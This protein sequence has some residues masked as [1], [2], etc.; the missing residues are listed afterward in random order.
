MFYAAGG[1]SSVEIKRTGNSGIITA[2]LH[3]FIALLV[4]FGVRAYLWLVFPHVI[5]LHEA[6]AIAYIGIARNIIENFSISNA[7][8]FP[9]FYPALI[10]L[11]SLVAGNY[12]SGARWASILAGAG[13]VVPL[14]LACRQLMSSR[15]AF[16]AV[17]LA[18]GFD[19][20]VDYS[21]QPITQASYGALIA[22]GVWLGLRCIG[23]SAPAL[24]AAFGL[25]SAA[26]YLT[27]PE[28]ILF[29]AFNFP[30][31]V[32]AICKDTGELKGR[33]KRILVL[34]AGF[35]IPF[36]WYVSFLKQS[37]GHWSLS[38][39]SGVT[40]IGVDASLKL[41]PGGLTYGEAVAGTAGISNLFPGIAA[42]IKT[43]LTQ[44]GKF[45]LV[46]YSVVPVL[47]FLLA[48]AG[49]ALLVSEVLRR[50]RGARLKAL[51]SLV[52]FLSPL[53]M[54]APVMVF[55]K[56]SV[57][58]GYIL[59]FFMVV[60]CCCAKGIAW[61][62]SLLGEK[63]KKPACI[64]AVLKK[65][66]SLAILASLLLSWYLFLPVYQRIS[67]DEFQFM[68]AQQDFLLRQTGHWFLH[69]TDKSAK[70]MSRWSNIGYYGERG[71]IALA[72]G[73][74]GE[75]IAYAKRNGITHIVIDSDSVPR[76]RPQLLNLLD[77]SIPHAGLTPVYADER[78][79]TRV[80]IYQVK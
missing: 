57:T 50:E 18:A 41:L 69:N 22:L 8:H 54:L 72:D 60:L 39:K 42:F 31:L 68:G 77:P 67:S 15:A 70:L 78:F 30:L 47:V 55:D 64:P 33:L 52:L 6:D 3:V 14:Y 26:I 43:Y 59:P 48:V 73:S 24:L 51:C 4:A 58:P 80:V 76:R 25:T 53:I 16:C 2:T 38:G 61:L 35:L 1:V 12:E 44:L 36:F 37:T 11:S 46:A 17:L 27:R 19:Q 74:I 20:F 63:I 75:V 71:W 23:K 28:G 34:S 13:M 21:L 40:S 7:I 9:P 49:M 56:I 79:Y 45:A 5:F 10:A 62:E 32:Y 65:N 29:F 66:I